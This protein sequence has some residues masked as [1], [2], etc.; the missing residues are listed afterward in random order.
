MKSS[1]TIFLSGSVKK[2]ETDTRP[3]YYFWSES[4]EQQLRQGLANVEVKLLNPNSITLP[5]HLSKE[6][7]QADFDM[8]SNS[9]VVLV[10]ART[11]K[12]LGVGAEMVLARQAKIPVLSLC[13]LGSEYRGV[14]QLADGTE[15][16]WVHAFVREFSDEIFDTLGDLVVW[17]QKNIISNK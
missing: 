8:L 17:L 4:D 11:K 1:I 7:F 14:V 6:R 10:D 13:P 16:E 15:K 2:G 9:D 5:K 12:G 3:N